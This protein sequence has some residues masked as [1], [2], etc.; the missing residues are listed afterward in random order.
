LRAAF[1]FF[2]EQQHV[3]ESMAAPGA[4]SEWA[5]QDAAALSLPQLPQQPFS[6]S[7]LMQDWALS[8]QQD[9]PPFPAQQEGM[10]LLLPF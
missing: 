8:L 6:L 10:C 2:P 5:Q 9:L 4:C 7:D 1:S 3:P